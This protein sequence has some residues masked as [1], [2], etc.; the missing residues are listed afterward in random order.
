[1]KHNGLEYSIFPWTE[2]ACGQA[3]FL[4]SVVNQQTEQRGQGFYLERSEAVRAYHRALQRL[5]SRENP[6]EYLGML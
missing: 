1:M 6:F 2:S 4:L 5:N 3:G